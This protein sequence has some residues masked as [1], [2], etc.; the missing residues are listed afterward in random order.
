MTATAATTIHDAART[1]VERTIEYLLMMDSNRLAGLVSRTDLLR[2]TRQELKG[3][4]GWYDR[5]KPHD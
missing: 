1:M 5:W 2:G 4:G 3:N